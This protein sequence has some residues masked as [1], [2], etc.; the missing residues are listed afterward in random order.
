MQC[1]K[2]PATHSITSSAISRNSRLIVNPSSL[3]V[4]R[5]MTISNVVGCSTGSSPG[6]G[7]FRILSTYVAVQGRIARDLPDR[8][9]AGSRGLVV[10]RPVR[11]S[12]GR[13]G[14]RRHTTRHP[15]GIARSAE[16]LGTREVKACRV[17]AVSWMGENTGCAPRAHHDRTRSTCYLVE[18]TPYDPA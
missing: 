3:A 10:H 16:K 6:F 15:P 14:R 13:R 4:F 1:N 9:A 7:L 5:L 8:C 12:G 11:G 17:I 2:R 18:F